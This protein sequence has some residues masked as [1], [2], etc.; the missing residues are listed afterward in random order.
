[1]TRMAGQALDKSRGFDANSDSGRNYASGNWGSGSMSPEELAKEYGLDRSN[2]G[3]GEGHIYGR[4]ASGNDVYIGFADM[5]LASNKSLIDSHSKQANSAEVD[6]SGVPENL[7]SIG[8]IRGA[9]LSQWDGGNAAAPTA[10]KEDDTFTYSDTAAKA[11]AGTEA[12]E[13]VMLPQQGQ[14]IFGGKNGKTDKIAQEYKDAFSLKLGEYQAPR[15][16]SDGKLA[17]P[18]GPSEEQENKEEATVFPGS[19][20]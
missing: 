4:D 18:T 20:N 8:D 11:K 3:K 9:I 14:F 5:G 17:N 2:P 7:S 19:F 12:F 15:N 16:K 13:E 6:H 10:P 1:M